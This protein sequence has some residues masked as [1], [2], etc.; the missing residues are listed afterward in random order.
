MWGA[1]FV[2]QD[3][4]IADVGGPYGI[5]I[6]ITR[7]PAG[8]P[9]WKLTRYFKTKQEQ[10]LESI[11]IPA[12]MLSTLLSILKYELVRSNQSQGA[13]PSSMMMLLYLESAAR[14]K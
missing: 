13:L 12:P 4:E 2:G 7:A 10:V 5:P 3:V 14:R 9:G 6:K 1:K 11:F 8:L